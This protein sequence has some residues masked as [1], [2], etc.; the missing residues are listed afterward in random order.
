MRRQLH[1]VLPDVEV[2]DGIAEAIP[3]SP[4]PSTPSPSP[5]RSTGSTPPW[6]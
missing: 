1:D 6:R 3:P 4:A 5:R 2:V